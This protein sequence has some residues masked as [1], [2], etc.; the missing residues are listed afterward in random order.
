MA[1]ELYMN[2]GWIPAKNKPAAISD[3]WKVG[4][5]SYCGRVFS[6]GTTMAMMR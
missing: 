4:Y 3:G 1:L 6:N 5:G 2:F